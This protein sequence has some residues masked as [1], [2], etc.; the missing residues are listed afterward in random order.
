MYGVPG[1]MPPPVPVRRH[2]A[3]SARRR[4]GRCRDGP[5]RSRS[6]GTRIKTVH[7]RAQAQHHPGPAGTSSGGGG[8]LSAHGGLVRILVADSDEEV[9]DG[10]TEAGKL[11]EVFDD[12]VLAQE[13]EAPRHPRG[14]WQHDVASDRRPRPGDSRPP[15]I[16]ITFL[17]ILPARFPGETTSTARSGGTGGKLF[18]TCDRGQRAWL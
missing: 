11:G 2:R 8:G 5:R 12:V 16:P 15:G 3:A 9:G 18:P 10:T 1:I 4:P 6:S 13:R 17:L 7:T 14:T